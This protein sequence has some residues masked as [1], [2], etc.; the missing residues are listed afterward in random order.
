MNR[1]EKLEY[2]FGD[3]QSDFVT[4]RFGWLE[5]V[6]LSDTRSLIDGGQGFVKNKIAPTLEGSHG[7]GNLS[8]SVLVCIALELAS[9]VYT[10]NTR[11]IMGDKYRVQ[12]NVNRFVK[13]FFPS[14]TLARLIPHL[15]WDGIRNGNNH[16]FIPKILNHTTNKIL[17]QFRADIRED[18]LSFISKDAGIIVIVIN[19]VEFYRIL[20][21]AINSYKINLQRS[22]L[23]QSRFIKA[24]QSIENG[25]SKHSTKVLKEMN[26]LIKKVKGSKEIS[27][28]S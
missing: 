1:R 12:D 13:R 19:S 5:T 2:I 7:G 16:L 10:G 4:N 28:F 3:H 6:I 14:R 21:K 23:L 20:K 17:F 25:E 18:K 27:L 8:I 15:L 22:D 24:W 11:Y 26:Y 9:A